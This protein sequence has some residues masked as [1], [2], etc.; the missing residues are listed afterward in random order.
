[1]LS[2]GYLDAETVAE[3]ASEYGVTEATI[4]RDRY[5][6]RAEYAKHLDRDRQGER[7]DLV[8][9]VREASERAGTWQL[10]KLE[11]DLLPVAPPSSDGSEDFFTT[12]E[13]AIRYLASFPADLLRRA[14]D[15]QNEGA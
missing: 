3:L 7:A 15:L 9:R 6:V 12:E 13:E 10:L 4:R 11:A 1:M 14:L 5:T 2:G 8:A